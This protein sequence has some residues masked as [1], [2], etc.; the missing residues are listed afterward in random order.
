MNSTLL[1]HKHNWE[2]IGGRINLDLLAKVI[3]AK[4]RLAKS[5]SYNKYLSVKY[6]KINR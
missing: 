2:I 4:A 1:Q 5:G 6:G 3:E